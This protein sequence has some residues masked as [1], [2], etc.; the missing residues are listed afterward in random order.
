MN[1]AADQ[2]TTLALARVLLGATAWVA[3]QAALKGALL[4]QNAPQSPYILRVFAAREVAL[5]GITLMAPPALKPA[6]VKVGIA[7]DSADAAAGA[8]AIKSGAVR[9]MVGAVL[10]GMAASAIVA[11]VIGL[12][13]QK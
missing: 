6:L 13:Q 8:L 1:L 10:T 12:G 7:V 3:P 9:P 2:A 5:G 11:G 4:D